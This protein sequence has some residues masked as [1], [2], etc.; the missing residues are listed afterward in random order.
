P[1]MFVGRSANKLSVNAHLVA[2]LLHTAF[3]DVCHRKLTRNFRKVARPHTI[4]LRRS[5][6][7]DLECGD[8]RE[9]S[10]DFVL[11]GRGEVGVFLVAAQVFKWQNRDGF[12]IW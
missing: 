4:L 9:S 5:A 7:D 2:S 1:K 10:H 3:E 12:F 6:R 11:N 8:L